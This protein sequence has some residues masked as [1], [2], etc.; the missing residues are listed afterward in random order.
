MC[1]FDCFLK[2]KDDDDENI[3]YKKRFFSIGRALIRVQ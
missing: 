1:K 2:K 3:G